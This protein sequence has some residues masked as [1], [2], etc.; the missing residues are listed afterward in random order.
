VAGEVQ[1]NIGA[2]GQLVLDASGNSVC[3]VTFGSGGQVSASGRAVVNLSG[4]PAGKPAKK[5][6]GKKFKPR[7]ASATQ[8]A[9]ISSTDSAVVNVAG[10]V[11][12]KEVHKTGAGAVNTTP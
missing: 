12:L 1:V 11:K 7:A 10:S 5:K 8:E 6:Q 9:T 2:R 3:N 4:P